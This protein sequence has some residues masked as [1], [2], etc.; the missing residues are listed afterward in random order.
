MGAART[1]ATSEGEEI[2][3]AGEGRG[4]AGVWGTFDLSR[5]LRRSKVHESLS[6]AQWTIVARLPARRLGR[7]PSHAVCV[8]NEPTPV[9]FERSL[10]ASW[11]M[12]RL[13]SAVPPD[14]EVPVEF[15]VKNPT[16]VG[17]AL[18]ALVLNLLLLAP[19]AHA[20]PLQDNQRITEGYI[21]LAYELGAVVDPTL[22]PGGTSAVRPIWFVFAP[23]ASRTGGQ[24]MLAAATARRAIAAARVRPSLTLT[25]ALNRLQV[26]GLVRGTVETL[27]LELLLRGLTIDGAASLASLTTAMNGQA[28][29]DTRT[30]LAT[31]SRL[32]AL[33]W[34]APGTAPLDK[35][36][37]IAITLERLLNEGNLAIF[38]DIGGSGRAFGDWRLARGGPA[39]SE[40]V[41]AGFTL[42]GA[43]EAQARQA[44]A[45]A[46]AH[47]E[48]SPRPFQLNAVLPGLHW[49]SLL[50]AAFALY[51]EARVAPTPA[52]RDALIA[53]GNNYIAWREQYDMA[54]PVFAPGSVLP[55]EVSRPALLEAL[56]PLL[57]TDF[58][59][60]EWTYADYA[61]SQ[62][63][64]DGNPLTSPPT[65]YNWSVFWDRWSGI[66]YAF[67]Q[68]Y[69]EPT[70]LWVMPDP[71]VDP[72]E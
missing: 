69:T 15:P 12:T 53:V 50:V 26:S 32:G 61:Y 28:L 38:T 45:Y 52:R 8:Q 67:D 71:L 10:G 4:E 27:S 55:G 9:L 58:G 37:A 39:T 34:S 35:A 17:R 63:D 70:A 16:V 43:V 6:R 30:L 2:K 23:H 49:K 47:A 40:Q 19:R 56:T 24:G 51:E 68:A 33:Y 13:Q 66:L 46:V 54:Q 22:P 7:N 11:V 3:T 59:T 31:S 72:L 48:D 62:P 57:K 29:L 5:G 65:E 41:L 21:Q 1:G 64:R 60:Q 44:F 20:T 14:I 42:P 25:E 36:E 18:G